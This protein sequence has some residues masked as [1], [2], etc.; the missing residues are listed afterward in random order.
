MRTKLG[1]G[2][3][4]TAMVMTGV[5]T[6]TPMD[7]TV[8]V[9]NLQGD[10][11]GFLTPFFLATQNGTYDFFNAGDP[12]SASLERLAEDGSTGPRI[13]AALNSGG[14]DT[15]LATDGG[16][17]APGESRSVNFTI[18]PDNPLTQAL[19]FASMFI[20]SNDAFIGND[21]PD[22][23]RL[24]DGDGNL[25]VRDGAS[26]FLIFGNDVYDAGTE[27]NDEIAENTAFLAQAAPNT[28]A[29]EASVVRSHQGFQGSQGFGGDIG[30]IL[31]AFPG[32]DFTLPGT[33]IASISIVP[34]P[35]TLGLLMMGAIA[36]VRRRLNCR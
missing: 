11:G 15:A 10:G 9:T 27:I 20:P 3:I 7:I 2:G 28:G 25:V 16:P 8:T 30:N 12:A 35:A 4:L 19:S 22:L 33:P 1:L 18:D 36:A 5:V 23:L 31:T 32:A 14:V 17:I 21:S 34:E 29:I 26:T 6:A 24:F 13:T